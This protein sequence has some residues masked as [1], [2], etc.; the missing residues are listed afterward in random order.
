MQQVLAD[1]M[2]APFFEGISMDKM[3]KHQVSM[4]ANSGKVLNHLAQR[5]L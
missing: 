4:Q 1:P 3:R 2:L 5:A